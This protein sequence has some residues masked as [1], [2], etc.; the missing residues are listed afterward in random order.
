[1]IQT[2]SM[3]SGHLYHHLVGK[4]I[5]K[6]NK[7]LEYDVPNP[8][9]KYLWCAMAPMKRDSVYLCGSQGEVCKDREGWAKVYL[10]EKLKQKIGGS[11]KRGFFRQWEKFAL[12]SG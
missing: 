2:W 4:E 6:V 1:M 5:L 12:L 3:P 9:I 8:I 10:D 7:T 11:V